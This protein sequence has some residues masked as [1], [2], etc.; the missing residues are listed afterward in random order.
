MHSLHTCARQI[1]RR[2]PP[3]EGGG[4]PYPRNRNIFRSLNYHP[5]TTPPPVFF[6]IE[7]RQQELP[8]RGGGVPAIHVLRDKDKDM[9]KDMCQQTGPYRF[10]VCMCQH[11]GNMREIRAKTCDRHVSRDGP[12]CIS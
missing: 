6:D 10:P 5:S 12:I 2:T 11:M 3:S 8:P 7:T 9:S 4:D 1:G